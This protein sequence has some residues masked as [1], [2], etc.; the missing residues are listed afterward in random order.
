MSGGDGFFTVPVMDKPWLVYSD[1]QGG[2]LNITDT[3]TGTQ[4]TI[5]PYPNRVGS[6][7]DAMI[8]HKY[9]FNWNS[10]IA[11]S[12]QNPKVVYF[13]GNVLFKSTDYGMSWTAD[14]GR[15]HDQRS[16]EAAVV[17]RPDRRRQH[18]GGVPLHDPDDRAVAAGL[19]R[20]LGRHR[21]RQRAGHA[22]RRED[23]DERVQERAG[24]Q[25]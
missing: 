13:G 18:G 17:G 6:V 2:M 8:S 11:L 7:G 25:A 20:H 4:K 15:P 19:E 16:G 12:P 3:R 22:R 1:A 5:Y 24:T 10:P 23:V 14:L 9:R 21:R